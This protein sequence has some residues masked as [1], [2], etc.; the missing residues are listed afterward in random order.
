MRADLAPDDFVAFEASPDL[1]RPPNLPAISS[2]K[3]AELNSY[4]LLVGYRFSE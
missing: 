4:Y 2:P 3:V 1:K